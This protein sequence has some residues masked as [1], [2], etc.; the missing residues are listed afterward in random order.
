VESD[1]RFTAGAQYKESTRHYY[2][3]AHQ[4]YLRAL[5]DAIHELE[6]TA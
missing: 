3:V 2:E 5:Q 1:R 4:E 6:A